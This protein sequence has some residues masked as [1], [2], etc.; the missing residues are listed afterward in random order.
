MQPSPSGGLV[1]GSRGGWAFEWARDSH[2]DSV[3]TPPEAIAASLGFP[4]PRQGCVS[5]CSY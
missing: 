1:R 2:D 5:V 4:V 3:V